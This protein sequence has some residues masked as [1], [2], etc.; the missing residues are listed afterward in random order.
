MP[1]LLTPNNQISALVT[2]VLL[3]VTIVVFIGGQYVQVCHTFKYS[4]LTR[5]F[6]FPF[7]ILC[8][9][10]DIYHLFWAMVSTTSC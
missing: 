4:Y 10:R 8:S 2:L 1:P 7:P 6:R 3:L 9:H 5:F